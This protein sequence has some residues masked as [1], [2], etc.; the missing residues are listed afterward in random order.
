MASTINI[1]WYHVTLIVA[2]YFMQLRSILAYHSQPFI[3]SIPR[4][5]HC[6]VYSSSGAAMEITNVCLS[7]GNND[8]IS[9]I[10]WQMMPKE[11][12]GLV[13]PNGAG[14]YWHLHTYSLWRGDYHIIFIGKSTLLKALTKTGGETLTIREGDISLSKN[15][16]LGYLEQKGI[17]EYM[18]SS[19]LSIL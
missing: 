13:G 19:S 10:N 1:H 2:T 7:I 11:R 15:S 12:W 6:A 16:R 18:K 17:A 8:I 14:I 3:R 5:N 4:L 9:R